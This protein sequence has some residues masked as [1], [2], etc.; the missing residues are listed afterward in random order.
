MD[1]K[2]LNEDG[3]MITRYGECGQNDTALMAAMQ[4]PILDVYSRKFQ[5]ISNS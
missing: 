3:M 4:A 2:F 5:G 1:G